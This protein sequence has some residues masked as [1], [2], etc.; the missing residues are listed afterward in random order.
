MLALAGVDDKAA[1]YHVE[2]D[3]H[4]E[5]AWHCHRERNLVAN[6]VGYREHLRFPEDRKPAPEQAER[7]QANVG[8]AKN[9]AC[10][11]P[12]RPGQRSALTALREEELRGPGWRL[13]HLVLRALPALFWAGAHVIMR[14]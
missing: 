10:P 14:T 8:D 3:Q 12:H 5:G 9:D 11:W 6:L 4:E 2:T 7:D 13:H 1:E